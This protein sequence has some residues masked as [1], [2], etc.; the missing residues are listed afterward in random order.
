[1][2]NFYKDNDDI[3]FLFR[4]IDLGELAEVCEEKF[5][6]SNEFDY[7]PA[8]TDEAMQNY[9]IVLDS[10]GQLSG[11]FIA[12]R[13][14]DVDREG[15]TLN[16]DGTVSYAK[17]TAENLEKLAQAEVM[18]EYRASDSSD[19]AQQREEFRQGFFSFYDKLGSNQSTE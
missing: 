18:F 4:H 1:M 3:Q 9:D 12:E 13:A 7:A 5:K 11:E 2:A 19:P 6:F 10:L 14:E 15:N 17:G 16:E 8:D